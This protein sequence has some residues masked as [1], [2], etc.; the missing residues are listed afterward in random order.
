MESSQKMMEEFTKGLSTE[1]TKGSQSIPQGNFVDPDFYIIGPGDI[2]S[3]TVLP[4]VP[5]PMTLTVSPSRT[6][7]IPRFG[8]ISLKN[9]SLKQAQDTLQYFFS[10]KNKEIKISLELQQPRLCLVTVR[11]NV[12]FPNV[13]TI[14]ASFQISSAINYANKVNSEGLPAEQY[15]AISRFNEQ[16]RERE[17]LFGESKYYPVSNY[18]SRNVIVLHNDG[19]SQDIDIEKSKAFNNSRYNPYVREGDEIIVPFE[20]DNYPTIQV[21]GEVNRPITVPY[22]TGDV[23]SL[24]LKLGYGL[25]TKADI[26]NIV[27]YNGDQK[28]N[29]VSD[30][31]GNLKQTDFPINPGSILVVGA[32]EIPVKPRIAT[33]SVN[34]EVK[35]PGVY[36][37]ENEKTRL[38]DLVEMAG[39]FSDKA[40][41][42]LANIYRY[43]RNAEYKMDVKKEFNE[44][45]QY[46]NLTLEDTTRFMIDMQYS[47]DFV[48]CDFDKLFRENDNKYNVVLKG[49]DIINIP[50]QPHQV[51]VYGQVKNPGYIEFVPG[52]TLEYYVEKAGGYAD[53][54]EK[55][56]SRIIRGRNLIWDK[57]G[58]EVYVNAGDQVYIPRQPDIPAWPEIQKYGTYAALVGAAATLINILYGIYLT[59]T[60]NK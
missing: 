54:A 34:G 30:T 53:G 58:K 49:G 60:R 32:K 46:S 6:L 10:Q 56:R 27:L 13:Y 19:S 21:A 11:G 23:A 20:F 52:K 48:S 15:K 42:P 51:Y 59:Q 45:F 25:T 35:K 17:K 24:L 3:L 18:Y 22:K 44:S 4:L 38:R 2:L 29:I 7:T 41:L 57:P 5:Y 55:E 40:H 8:E 33:V 9:K 1:I 12:I 14:P 50:E 26:N 16:V 37:I 36:V 43:N 47:K 31:A 28:I 39:G